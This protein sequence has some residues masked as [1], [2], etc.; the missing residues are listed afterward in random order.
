[1]LHLSCKDLLPTILL[2]GTVLFCIWVHIMG[3]KQKSRI[4]QNIH[5]TKSAIVIC[6]CTFILQYE[7][8]NMCTRGIRAI[9][10]IG[11]N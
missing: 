3:G 4:I 6:L 7:Y 1:M 2:Q 11:S 10:I 9:T 5:P 8:T